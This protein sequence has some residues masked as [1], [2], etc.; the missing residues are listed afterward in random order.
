M[1]RFR[2]HSSGSGG[3]GAAKRN[4]DPSARR[5]QFG[6]IQPME[7]ME[8]SSWLERLFRREYR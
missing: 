2:F 3:G 6:Q 4:L 8:R 7:T 1:S 5:A